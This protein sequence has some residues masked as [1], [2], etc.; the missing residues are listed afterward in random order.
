MFEAGFRTV[1][2]A[3]IVAGLTACATTVS[4]PTPISAEVPRT[5]GSLD[6]DPDQFRFAIVGDRTGSHRP[7]VFADAMVKLELLQ[8][9]FVVTVGDL[10]EGYTEDEAEIIRQW[11][12]LEGRLTAL[13][14]PL[15]YIA[16][17]HDISNPVMARIWRERRGAAYWSFVHKDVL[18]IGLSTEDPPVPLSAQNQ[19]SSRQL[20]A[21]MAR[22]PEE[23]QARLL[24]AVRDRG[25]SPKLPGAVAISD[26]QVNFVRE[27][28]ASHA[29]ARWTFFL[30][31][32][33]GWQYGS[34][35]FARIEQMLTDRPY[36][37][38]AGHE[39]YYTHEVRNGRDYIVMGTTGGVWLRDGP[40]RVDHLTLVTVTD[41][42]PT[43]ANL[44]TDGIFPK[45]GQPGTAP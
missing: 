43:I 23:T 11:D 32:K 37:M 35:A 19:A 3:M 6:P 8:P 4:A 31:H 38:I 27:T 22:N 1:V 29:D 42:G 21:A 25:A 34:E 14:S 36:T 45:E 24:E 26:E 20:Q 12:E 10:I 13:S 7:G 33:P 40:G 5:Q 15:F 30:M 16:G 41:N 18:F 39:H 17:N 44:R 9:D 2:L 28:L